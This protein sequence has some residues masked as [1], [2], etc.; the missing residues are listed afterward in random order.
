MPLTLQLFFLEDFNIFRELIFEKNFQKYG[1]LI[2]LR[3]PEVSEICKFLLA[4]TPAGQIIF[5][6]AR[7]ERANEKRLIFDTLFFAVT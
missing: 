6:W 7:W 3:A 4:I 5:P 1:T 2:F